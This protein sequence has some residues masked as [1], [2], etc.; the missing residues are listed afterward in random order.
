MVFAVFHLLLLV[1]VL[2][3]GIVSLAQ[4]NFVRGA[5]ILGCLALYYVLA[6]HDQVMKEI[7]RKRTR[8]PNPKESQ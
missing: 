4:G 1:A 5:L 8:K 3:W 2:G 6:L 7:R